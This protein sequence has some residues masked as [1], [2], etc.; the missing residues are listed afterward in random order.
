MESAETVQTLSEQEAYGYATNLL[1]NS[2][3]SGPEV[4]ALLV[5]QG[6][7]KQQAIDIVTAL[8]AQIKQAKDTQANKDMLYGA[9]WCVG[10]IVATVANFGFIFWGAIVFGGIQFFKGVINK[11]S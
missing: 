7:E 11:A 8:E 2:K 4:A 10:G 1:V 5:Q 9:L 6:I 3:R